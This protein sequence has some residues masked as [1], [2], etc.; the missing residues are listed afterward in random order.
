MQATASGCKPLVG[1]GGATEC[2]K[3]M[4]HV[5]D[6]YLPQHPIVR[7]A[8]KHCLWSRLSSIFG[9]NDRAPGVI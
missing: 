9:Q 7:K 1:T 2:V 3:L 6:E 8:R 5:F 4:R